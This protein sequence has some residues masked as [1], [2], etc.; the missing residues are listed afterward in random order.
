MY[1]TMNMGCHSHNHFRNC[2]CIFRNR[3]ITVDILCRLVFVHCSLCLFAHYSFFLF[4]CLS[5]CI[6]HIQTHSLLYFAQ[7]HIALIFEV[8]HQPTTSNS[9]LLYI[10]IPLSLFYSILCI[11]YCILLHCILSALHNIRILVYAPHSD[12]G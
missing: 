3:N 5:R 12:G 7:I 2:I 10:I 6:T 1:T 11:L 4:L 9:S 8:T